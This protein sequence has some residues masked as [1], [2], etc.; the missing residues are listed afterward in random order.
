VKKFGES[1]VGLLLTMAMAMAMAISSS[2]LSDDG[3]NAAVSEFQD[4]KVEAPRGL[5]PSQKAGNVLR[6]LARD[7]GFKVGGWDDK[8]NRIMVIKQTGEAIDSYDPD[9]LQKREALAIE[10]SLLAKATIIESFT[11]TASAEN[12]L[13]VP[14]NPIAKQLEAE[15]KQI[16][17]MEAQAQ[18]FYLQAQKETSVLLSAYDQAQA[19]E[20]RGVTFGDRLNSLLEATIKKLDETFDSQQITEDKKQRLSD[21]KKR[22]DKARKI[23]DDKQKLL[24]EVQNKIAELQGQVKKETRSA[25]ETTSSMPLFG[26]TTLMQVESFDDLRGQ[27]NIASLVVWSPKLE[28]EARG[29]LLGAGKGKPRKNK[30]SIDEWLDK[31]N[32]SSMV[33][34]RRYLASDG[35]TNFMGI[36]AVEYD[37]DDSGS[38]SMLEEE[39]ILWAKQAA[40]LSLKASVESVKSAERLKRDIRGADGKVESKILKDFSANIQESVK[41]LTIRGLETLR[42]EETVH[43]PTGKNIIVAVANVNSAL[44]VKASDIMKDMYATLKEVNADQSFIQGEEA[45]MKAEADKTLNNKAIFDAGVA[46]GSN[47]VATEYDSRADDRASIGRAESQQSKESIPED[48]SGSSGESQSGSWAGDI[49]VDDDF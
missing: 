29:M 1:S 28:L 37:P 32:L 34:A 20:L 8:K 39:A 45:G 7:K 15:Q 3:G 40:I 5:S 36:S 31:Q 44:A 46:S 24:E 47:Q 11:T 14:G 49:E 21:V 38:Y 43:E 26:A 6:K 13:S 12:I 17:A 30:I 18:K 19:E 27:Y 9:F 42:I 10:A 4:G 23:E 2:A 22:L 48:N 16:K 33:G 35:S 25:I 41:N